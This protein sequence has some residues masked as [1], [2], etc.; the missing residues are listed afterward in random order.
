MHRHAGFLILALALALPA[1]WGK[2]PW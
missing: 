2:D 1:A